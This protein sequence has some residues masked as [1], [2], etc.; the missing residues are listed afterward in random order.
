MTDLGSASAIDSDVVDEAGARPEP[1]GR[2]G[3]LLRATAAGARSNWML[4]GVLAAYIASAFVVPTLAP[5][6]ISDDP[7]YA[8][9]VEILLRDHRLV[10]MPVIVPTQVFLIGWGALFGAIFHDSLGVFRVSVVVLM[11]GSGIAF[12]LLCMELGVSRARSALGTAVYL[13]CPL[14]YVLGFTFM[15]DPLPVALLVISLAC[16]VRSVRGGEVDARWLVA[17]SVVTALAFLVRQPAFVTTLGVVTL[18]LVARRITRDRAGLR[19]LLQAALVPVIAVVGYYVWFKF[20]YGGP[21]SYG[22]D[23]FTN[24]LF[25]AGPV[26]TLSVAGTLL[27]YELYYVGFFVFPIAIALVGRALVTA[28]RAPRS[29]FLGVAAWLGVMVVGTGVLVASGRHVRWPQFAQFVATSGLG[30]ADLRGG[31]VP[32]FGSKAALLL[33]VLFAVSSLVWAFFVSRKARTLLKPA[34]WG[35]ALI[36]AVLVW[37]VLAIIPTSVYLHDQGVSYDRYLAPLV[38]LVIVLILW[39]LRDVRFWL[40]AAWIVTGV[41][42]V[43]SVMGTRDYL[44]FQRTVWKVANDAHASGIAYR[45]IDGGA[46]W[47][48]YHLFE[49]SRSH[50]AKITLKDLAPLKALKDFRFSP[51]DESAWW[52]PFYAPAD[53]QEFVVSSEPLKTY[54][55]LRKVPYSQ[56]LE[57]DPTFIYLLQRP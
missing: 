31:R 20:L 38:P 1:S 10:L 36:V 27:T 30:P 55:V 45:R 57:S 35:A 12:Y 11:W 8:R 34:Q 17:G 52:V 28:R 3:G 50:H 6:S 51:H 24:D 26:A 49:Y 14:T 15:T 21:K 23:N 33:T 32:L 54:K 25:R 29:A 39:S 7:M 2:A 13:F 47:D 19:T 46:A 37:Q 43:A 48:A 18:L 41:F 4:L 40:P 9:S 53:T 16:Y 42:V 56:W 5:V 22:Q 44:T